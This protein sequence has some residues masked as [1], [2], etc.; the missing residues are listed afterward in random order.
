MDR[1][2]LRHRA[3][4]RLRARL[5]ERSARPFPKS[6]LALEPIARAKVALNR[7]RTRRE[8]GSKTIERRAS[9]A[10]KP[11]DR[12]PLS[13]LET[14]YLAPRRHSNSKPSSVFRRLQEG[15]LFQNRRAMP[16]LDRCR[17]SR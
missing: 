6:P 3:G 11:D 15:T 8:S 2:E 10:K 13:F 7:E 16:L 5:G 12:L 4:H 17:L 9:N 1:T 14:G